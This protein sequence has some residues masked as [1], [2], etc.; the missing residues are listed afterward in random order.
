MAKKA[1]KKTEATVLAGFTQ[2]L[3]DI[4]DKKAALRALVQKQ[5]DDAGH[6]VIAFANEVPNTFELRRPS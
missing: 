3:Q 2:P 4:N 5:N 6:K 1:S